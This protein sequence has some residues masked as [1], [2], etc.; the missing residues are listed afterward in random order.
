MGAI[1]H[2]ERVPVRSLRRRVEE[3]R[4][5]I[6]YHDYRYYVLD[7]PEISDAE[8]D[9]LLRELGAIEEAHPELIT[10]DSPT[11]RVGGRPSSLFAPV[12][13]R[14]PML[15]LENAYTEEDLLAWIHRSERAAPSPLDFVCELKIDG[16]AVSLTYEDGQYVRGATR[17]DGFTGEDI[18]ANLRT[19]RPLPL[20]L[21]GRAPPAV[22]EVRGEVYL[23]LASFRRLNQELA[24]RGQAPFANPRNAAAGSLRQKD[25]SVTASRPLRL[26]CYGIGYVA[27]RR[28]ARHSEALDYLRELGL[29]VS[30]AVT[31]AESPREVLAYFRR[32]QARRDEL[33]YEADGVVVKVDPLA[34]Q[35]RLGTTSRAPRWAIALKFPPKEQTAR[36]ERIEAQ[37]GR[38]GVVTPVAVLQ[39]V[40]VGGVTIATATLHNAEE[41]RRRDIRPGDTVLVRRAG[42]VIPEIVGPVL[43]RRP[44]KSR[45]WRFPSRCSSC[46]ARLVRREGEIAWRCPNRE[47]CP[48]QGLRWLLH[49]ASRGAMDIAHLGEKTARRL[50]ERGLV[51]DPADLYALTKKELATLPGFQERASENLLSAIAASRDRPLWRLLVGLNIPHVGPAVAQAL[52]AAFPSCEALARASP[53]ELSSLAGIGPAIAS[54]VY[55]W[56]Q[57]KENRRLLERLRR[58]GVRMKEKAARA[59]KGPLFGKRIVLTG[60]LDSMTREEAK[61]AARAAGA[62]ISE[63]VSAQT[64]LVVVGRRPGSKLQAARALGVERVDEE[65]FT[66]RLIQAQHP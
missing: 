25:P 55:A 7:R 40:A 63:E 64:D 58:A 54:R 45:P 51:S 42:E 16:V 27:G 60:G 41:I 18:S 1:R 2:R 44:R 29:P 5:L 36:L 3:L 10:P 22:L 57:A 66:R 53:Q 21:R 13:H 50:M 4:E 39:P 43:S 49:Y 9:R 28:F 30:P 59:P 48:A 14:A 38:T 62:Q 46:G 23:P 56:L 12:R 6:C 37:T 35:E 17:G 52:T 20:K 8:Y 34:L 33:E 47:G 31:L 26:F 19:L 24:A 65:E 15:S 61:D 32:W 11:Q